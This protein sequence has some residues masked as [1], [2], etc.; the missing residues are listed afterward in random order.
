MM[1][2]LDTIAYMLIFWGMGFCL[3]A[4]LGMLRFP[5]VYTRYHAGT[6]GVTAGNLLI[7]AGV[8]IIEWSLV[9]AL[10]LLVIAVFFLMTNPMGTHAIARAAYRSRSA[11]ACLFTDAYDDYVRDEDDEELISLKLLVR[12]SRARAGQGQADGLLSAEVQETGEEAPGE[13]V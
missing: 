9:I 5:D 2:T 8:A 7:L 10:K 3:V 11:L 13:T 1:E 6:K 12:R 4:V